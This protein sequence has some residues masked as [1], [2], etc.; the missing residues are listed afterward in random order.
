MQ[1]N[2]PVLGIVVC[3]RAV[4]RERRVF[5]GSAGT[6]SDAAG[7]YHDVRADCREGRAERCNS[8]HHS[9]GVARAERVSVFR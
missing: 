9:D 5:G 7:S 1:R 4:P 8:V 6:C 2:R 3:N